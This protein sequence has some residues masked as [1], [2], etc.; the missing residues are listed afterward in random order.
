[1]RADKSMEEAATAE[2]VRELK[3]HKQERLMIVANTGVN[4]ANWATA[5]MFLRLPEPEWLIKE[6]AARLYI[7]HRCDPHPISHKT[8]NIMRT[9]PQFLEGLLLA[10]EYQDDVTSV[11]NWLRDVRNRRWGNSQKDRHRPV[12]ISRSFPP[13]L[14]HPESKVTHLVLLYHM[15][16]FPVFKETV[17]TVLG[18]EKLQRLNHLTR[19]TILAPEY[20]LETSTIIHEILEAVPSLDHMLQ[21]PPDPAV[22]TA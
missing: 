10:D 11:T 8:C 21:S 2:E 9:L 13:L 3:E 7:R 1:M 17:D 18:P 19:R 6:Q 14:T 5:K 12:P 4:G 20:H 16:L 15:G 22:P